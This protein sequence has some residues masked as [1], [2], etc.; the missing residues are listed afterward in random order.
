MSSPRT[1]AASK[2]VDERLTDLDLGG[3][4]R[5]LELGV[6]EGGDGLAEGVALL[7]V[8]DGV[9][10]RAAARGHRRHRDAQPL[11]LELV[12]Q[13]LEALPLLTEQV[14]HRHAAVLEEQLAGVLPAQAE[15]VELAPA[16]EAGRIGL[17]QQQADALVRRLGV[18]IGLRHDDEQVADL[19]VRDEGL[20]AVQDVVIAVA[21]GARLHVREVRSRC[22]AR[23]WRCRGRCPRRSSPGR[24]FCFCS[25]LP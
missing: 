7:D 4:L 19:P 3:Q 16:H 9:L 11:L 6:L 23:S 25:G 8:G 13:H 12:H 24:Y 2:L 17:D 15:L 22:P 5:E 20:R 10:E 1:W 14:R 21:D 18:R